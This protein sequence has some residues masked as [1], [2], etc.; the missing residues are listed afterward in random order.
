MVGAKHAQSWECWVGKAASGP[1]KVRKY[2]E[3]SGFET[4]A[5]G[6]GKAR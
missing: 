6:L 3:K 4:E 2:D 1:P 5:T